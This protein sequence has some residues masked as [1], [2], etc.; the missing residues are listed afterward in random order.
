MK[1]PEDLFD[2]ICACSLSK[3][4]LTADYKKPNGLL[5]VSGPVIASK[6]FMIYGAL[7][8]SLNRILSNTLHLQPV[9]LLYIQGSGYSLKRVLMR[10]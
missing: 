8:K 3:N 10:I 5:N 6:S 4:W 7:E 2:P 9:A 1:H